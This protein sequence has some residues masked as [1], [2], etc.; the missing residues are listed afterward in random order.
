[1]SNYQIIKPN[2]EDYAYIAGFIEAE[3]SL[4]ISKLKREDNRYRYCP[5]ISVG[6]KERE[7]LDYISKVFPTNIKTTKDAKNETVFY[8][9]YSANQTKDILNKI[10]K[11]LTFKKPQ[12]D[13]LLKVSEIKEKNTK[14]YSI[15]K[16]SIL[17]E[18]LMLENRKFN[19]RCHELHAEEELKNIEI[20][21]EPTN[22]N[23]AYIAGLV[24]GDG[25]FGIYFYDD[26]SC[27]RTQSVFSVGM[28]NIGGIKM[29]QKYFGG[30]INKQK[31]AFKI[32]FVNGKCLQFS[33]KI[34]QFLKCKKTQAA[35]C[36]E[37]EEKRDSL[38]QEEI[39]KY[40]EECKN[41]KTANYIP[42]KLSET[43]SKNPQ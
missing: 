16:T 34:L 21:T 14:L 18:E 20:N 15:N 5:T 28:N 43:N 39:N 23:L 30:N 36:I 24:D 19:S 6:V 7:V 9:R 29:I 31:K 38:K 40:I 41:L 3:G 42:Y 33:K 2:E 37:F 22:L 11:Y 13:I 26:N 8:I 25:S 1:M 12:A 32:T 10:Y 4:L 35:L 17:F 27:K